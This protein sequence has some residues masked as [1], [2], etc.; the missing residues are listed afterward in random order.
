MVSGDFLMRS[1]FD[2][3][4]GFLGGCCVYYAIVE[5]GVCYDHRSD[6]HCYLFSCTVDRSIRVPNLLLLV[7]S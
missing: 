1:Q 3:G 5:S 4:F 2:K 7:E 6:R